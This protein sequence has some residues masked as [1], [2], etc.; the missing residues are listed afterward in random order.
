M[1]R[2]W[3]VALAGG[4]VACGS[5]PPP[6]PEAPRRTAKEAKKELRGLIDEAYRVMRDG[7]PSDAMGLL[8]P[9][10]FFIGPG[11]A[12]V[13]LDRVGVLELAGALVD[14]RKQH[15]LKSFGLEL[16]AGPD[17][18]SAYAI[19]Q[20]E[21]DGVAFAVT[22]VAAEID[23]LWSLTTLEVTRAISSR[24]LAS[25]VAPGPLPRWRPE[26]GSKAAHAEAPRAMLAALGL[27]A[28]DVDDRLRQYG[29]DDD[30]AFVGPSPDEVSLGAKAIGKRWKKQ[31]PR[32]T[33]AATV[34]GASPDGEEFAHCWYRAHA[35]GG[36]ADQAAVE[37]LGELAEQQ[38]A[39]CE[40]AL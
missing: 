27:A 5:A 15:K 6:E 35:E 10:L 38:R 14:D 19:D 40:D 31:A 34:A 11:P 22:A 12:D 9:D 33:V 24:K 36:P 25:A 39:A 23:G 26:D 16:F 1:Q 13:G 3:V 2:F 20:L 21:Y 30:A 18:R 37:A 17:G 7:T 4:L 8:A 29:K 32:W 28:D